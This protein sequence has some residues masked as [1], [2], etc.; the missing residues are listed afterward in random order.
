MTTMTDLPSTPR[1]DAEKF[2]AYTPVFRREVVSVEFARQLEIELTTAVE[3][4]PIETAPK[5][6]RPI[7]LGGPGVSGEGFWMGDPDRNYRELTGWF[8]SDDDVLT[9][10]PTNPTHWMPLPEPPN[11]ESI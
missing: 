4:K 3:W 2:E 5:D 6:G 1:T 10:R 11:V 7:I 8:Y 9:A